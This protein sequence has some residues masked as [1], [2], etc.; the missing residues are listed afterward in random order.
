[1]AGQLEGGGRQKKIDLVREALRASLAKIGP[2]ARVGLAA[3]GHRRGNCTDVETIRAPDPVEAESMVTQ[4]GL[5]QPRGRGPLTFALRE[6]AKRLPQTAGPRS[7]LLIHD[8]AD[9]CHTDLCTAAAE[10]AAAD[11]ATH[12]VSVGAS[13]EDLAKM[14]CLAQ[15]TGGRHFKAQNAEQLA[16]FIGE[17]LRLAANERAVPD[18]TTTVVP[19]VPVPASG[20]P[21]LYLRAVL[22]PNTEPLNLPLHWTVSAE[23]RSEPPLFEAWA[24][25]PVV[26]VPPGRYV[27]AASNGLV[28]ASDTVTIRENRPLAVPLVL[29][30]AG[31]L[32]VK[33]AAHR[34]GAPLADAIVT[35][36]AAAREGAPLAAFRSG[37]AAPLLQAGRYIVRA[38]LGL[39][40]SD[41]QTV[42]LAA[43]RPTQVEIH[44][45]AGRLL[46]TAGGRDGATPLDAPM[47]IIMEDD[48][49]RPRREVARSAA[50][51]A[52]FVLPPGLYYIV[53]R[54]GEAEA[55]DRVEIGSG[56][57]VRR[58]PLT[59]PAGR[60]SLTT[61]GTGPLAGDLVS[62]T[63]SRIDEPKR[64]VTTTSRSAPVLSLP[65]GRYRVEA[66]YG[67]TNVRTVRDAEIRAGQVTQV[68]IEHQIA[69]LT[70]RLTGGAQAEVSW[71]VREDAGPTVWT[72][73]QAEAVATVQA[74][75]YQVAVRA[76][77]KRQQR[78][79]ELRA[80]DSRVVEFRG[81]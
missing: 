69:Q 65:P 22:A 27:V 81:D 78:T 68:A 64:A 3:F 61:S 53:A 34:T 73:G 44:L 31:A 23:G 57:V 38:E 62:Y 70:L 75:R 39:V 21:A 72:S 41:P 42:E 51:Q 10:L 6:V 28:S 11:I 30:G 36:S 24:A 55:H 32:R 37:E 58:P 2:Q 43:G 54:Q 20:R 71:E 76:G 14:A 19:P 15:T 77:D 67:L 25:S 59:V 56:D 74:G 26:P 18:F 9:N 49:P 63:V 4:L 50:R 13:P 12:V 16:A 1:M 48:P 40:R 80:G 52:E 29:G 47:F 46:L 60:L 17:A 45:N 7:L 35:V 8:S 5:I 66:R 33:V 79:V